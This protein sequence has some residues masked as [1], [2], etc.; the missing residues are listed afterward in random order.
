MRNDSF[1]D[2]VLPVWKPQMET[3]GDVVKKIKNQFDL[4]K[5]GHCGT[6]DPFAEGVLII[7]S[8]DKTKSADKLMNSIKVYETTIV[9]GAET[10]TLDIDGN[11][12]KKDVSPFRIEK[13]KIEAVIPKF[14]G[15]IK[16]RPPAF[17]AKKI[18]GVR[19]YKL[20]RTDVFVS[21][22]PVDIL[23][24]DIEIISLVNNELTIKV[25]C[26]K[27]TYI[28]KLGS[29]IAKSLG[30]FGYLKSLKRTRVGQFNSKNT[31][32][33]EDIAIWKDIPS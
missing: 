14:I 18:N 21:L 24:E 12:I 22:K 4:K 32:S 33:L 1:Q 20:A 26:H 15:K 6:L 17:S 23:I 13:K 11:I 28:R 8:G 10:D 16:Q 30:S 29:D 5:V 31:L 3:S 2:S 7:V 19:L 9:L 25:T 27:G